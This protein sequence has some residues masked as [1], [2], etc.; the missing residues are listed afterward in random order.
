MLCNYSISISKYQL[1][2]QY[3]RH[4]ND[5]LHKNTTNNLGSNIYLFF[6]NIY[7]KKHNSRYF[8]EFCRRHDNQPLRNLLNLSLLVSLPNGT[9]INSQKRMRN[10]MINLPNKKHQK[11]KA[12]LSNGKNYGL[13]LGFGYG[14]VSCHLQQTIDHN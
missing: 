7:K 1:H 11:G 13:V 2:L 3:L 14:L 9:K 10:K 12:N 8:L 6:Q 4:S 5:N